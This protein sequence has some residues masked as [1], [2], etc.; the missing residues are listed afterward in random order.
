MRIYNE[1]EFMETSVLS[2]VEALD[3]LVIVLNQ[4]TDNSPTIAAHLKEQY[5][6]KIKIYNYNYKVYTC[7]SKEHKESEYNDPFNMANLYNYSFLKATYEIVVKIDADQ[8]FYKELFKEKCDWIR[9]NLKKLNFNT[10]SYF[11]LNIFRYDG[12]DYFFGDELICSKGDHRFYKLDKYHFYLK[13]DI[14]EYLVDF[15]KMKF[16][17]EDHPLYLHC[18]LSKKSRGVTIASKNKSGKMEDGLD[19]YKRDFPKRFETDIKKLNL[20]T[21]SELKNQ[22]PNFQKVKQEKFLCIQE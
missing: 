16:F 11:G 20:L 22:H 17:F 9:K 6:E 2:V 5:P 4:C 10:Y 14:C 21:L 13:N 15:K 19:N 8:V 1:E 12:K 7:Y 3:E 18:K